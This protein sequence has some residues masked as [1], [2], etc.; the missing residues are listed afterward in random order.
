MN[1][2]VE[3]S[4]FLRKSKIIKDWRAGKNFNKNSLF[5][6]GHYYSPILNLEKIKER[7]HQIWGDTPEIRGINLNEELQLELLKH[8]YQYYSQM[9][10]TAEKQSNLRYKFLN[11]YYSF[12]DGIILYSLLRHLKPKRIIEIGSGYS[13]ALMLDT[14]ELFLQKTIQFTFIEPLPQRLNN[15]LFQREKH[16]VS[17]IEQDVQAVSLEIFKSLQA[18][19]ILFIDSSHVVK[20]GS[21]VNYLLFEI[22]PVLNK[23]VIIHFHDIYYPFEYPKE[24][25]FKG[26]NWNE[27]YFVRAFLMNNDQY[28]IILFSDYLHKFHPHAFE[29]MP[30]SYESTGSNFWLRKK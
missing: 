2:K 1:I 6:A 9:P 13:S 19:D 8:L 28:E 5:P 4:K 23:G 22:F 29:R 11:N 26:L 27:A 3:I 15:L 17:I 25:V 10:F 7:E 16:F 21:D 12:T 20:T 24:W 30:L 14:N 18:G